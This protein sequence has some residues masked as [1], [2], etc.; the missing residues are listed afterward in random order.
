MKNQILKIAGV[1]NIDEFYRKFPTE[2]AFMN[3]HSKELKKAQIGA[4]IKPAAMP[5][6]EMA[7]LAKT[8]EFGLT[9]LK[10]IPA[11]KNRNSNY[12]D[13]L[14]MG[15]TALP[16]IISGIS[17]IVEDQRTL[18]KSKKYA[19]LAELAASVPQEQLP[20]HQYV[21]PEDYLVE[22]FNK[23]GVAKNGASI[24]GN[25]T[26]IQNMYNSGDLYSDLGYEPLNDNNPKQYQLGGNV[27][28]GQL[29]PLLGNFASGVGSYGAGGGFKQGNYGKTASAVGGIIGSFFGPVGSAIGS[30]GGGLIGGAFDADAL[31]QQ[32]A[33]DEKR[34][35][36]LGSASFG[37]TRKQQFGAYTKNGGSIPEYEDGGWVSNDWMPQTIT[38]FG[39]YNMKELLA[40]P[41]DADMLR[42][43]GHLKEYTPPSARAM[44]TGRDLPYQMANGGQM[45]MGGELQTLWGGGLETISRNPYDNSEIIMPKGQS[46]DESDGRGRTGIGIKYGD[47][48]MSDYAEYGASDQDASVEVE[49]NEPMVKMADGGNADNLVVFGNMIE[50]ESKK[51]YKV[52]AKEI[53]KDN[54]KQTKIMQKA[55]LNA[56]NNDDDTVFGQFAKNTDRANTIG[57]DMKLKENSMTLKH[58]AA[59]Q[60]AI[61]DTAKEFGLESD[62]LAKG[63]VKYAKANDPYAEFGAKLSKA[64]KGK[65][66]K[67]Y[68]PE[69]ENFINKAMMLEQANSSHAL[70]QPD[71]TFLG[72]VYRGGASNYGT[73][74]YSDYNTPE[75]AKEFY[76]KEYWSKVK[77]LPAGLRTRALQM[78]I[79]TG[80][81]Y[82]ELMV[83]A[84]K[85]SVADRYNTKNQRKDKIITGNKDW[86]KS[87]AD[88]IKAYKEDPQAFLGKLDKEQDRYY[89]SYIA[90]NPSDI[91]PNTRK[92]F[93]DDYTGLARFASQ[94]Y[95]PS[96]DI[97]PIA[98]PAPAIRQTAIAQ[99]PVRQAQQMGNLDSEDIV[100][101]NKNVK[102]QSPMVAAPTP[103]ARYSASSSQ[104]P[105]PIDEQGDYYMPISETAAAIPTDPRLLGW[106]GTD[107]YQYKSDVSNAINQT[108]SNNSNDD[109]FGLT[110]LSSIMPYLRPTNQKPLDPAQLAGE[111]YAMA[112]NTKQPVFAQTFTPDLTQP[113]RISLQD[114]VNKI[115]SQANA[116]KRLA[117]NNP[118]ALAFIDAELKKSI[119]EVMGEQFRLNQGEQQRSMETNRQTMNDAKLKNLGIRQEQADKMAAVEVN[120]RKENQAILNSISAKTLQNKAENQQLAIGENMYNYRF[121]P[122]GRAYNVNAPYNF[123]MYGSGAGSGRGKIQGLPNDW[124]SLYDETGAFQ[125]TKKR[126]EKEQS[127]SGKNGAIVKAIKNL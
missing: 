55:A 72:G 56:N 20:K 85:M 98:Q 78:A 52:L 84:G 117:Q 53:A 30:A 18:D 92:E 49:R 5:K 108:T 15:I 73:G 26:E 104:F 83:A 107:D 9:K 62:A 31:A 60:N 111:M 99:A 120:T 76:Y 94:Q 90:N 116:S 121:D 61:L 100:I 34:D 43:G 44:Y 47:G 25:S 114:Q 13:A 23:Y 24:G 54:N 127:T 51:K 77:D 38:K 19:K 112:T 36:F 58:Y 123:N 68:D 27:D 59:K 86:E 96:N 48:G 11:S 88:I 41:H 82:G 87:K 1:K 102:K 97:T 16:E 14:N 46:H 63:K 103:Q 28:Y 101:E 22:D 119:S 40:P 2:E 17:G 106:N 71:G 8:K 122:Q 65:E 4:V 79:N 125:G 126:S 21:R 70:K 105:S 64:Q 7:N 50:D 6:V 118:A 81:P 74:T 95:I 42:A 113:T 45:A 66:V 29:A 67:K 115:T 3:K 12:T 75:K 57:P 33:T 80:D 91:N 69:F 110:A 109:N 35:A 37:N 32:Q 39:D 124:M 10:D 89:D 93:F